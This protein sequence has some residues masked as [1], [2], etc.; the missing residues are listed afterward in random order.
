LYFVALETFVFSDVHFDSPAGTVPLVP[1]IAPTSVVGTFVF[2]DW[3]STG[4]ARG[5]TSPAAT[6][7][8]QLKTEQRE[9]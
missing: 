8:V 3:P 1:G 9:D 4:L 6:G 5:S 2:G 7:V